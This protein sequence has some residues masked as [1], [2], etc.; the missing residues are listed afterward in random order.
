MDCLHLYP[1]YEFYV[2]KLQARCNVRFNWINDRFASNTLALKESYDTK[3]VSP[4]LGLNEV[5]EDFENFI[6][7]RCNVFWFF[8]FWIVFT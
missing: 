5:F 3:G 7:S 4:N 2:V 1:L 8:G 6:N